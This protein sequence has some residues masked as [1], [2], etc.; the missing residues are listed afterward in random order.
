M[1]LLRLFAVAGVCAGLGAGASA[2]TIGGIDFPDGPISF[3][4]SVVSY[5]PGG[6]FPGTGGCQD[7]SEAVGIPNF[8]GGDCDGYVSLGQGGSIVLQFTDNALT[9]SGDSS[10]DLHVFEIGDAVE[11]MLISISTNTVDW[12]D[13]G[14]LSGQPTSIDIDGVTGVVSGA[15]YSYV[16]I[17]DDPNSG[18]SGGVYSGADIDAVGAISSTA[19]VTPV[20]LPATGLMLVG[21]L[22]AL[23]SAKRRKRKQS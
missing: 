10:A 21:A 18:P 20:P 1:N 3:A 7:T 2:A 19:P 6:G 8:T 4:D 23:A 16:R 14:R 13:L 12:I 5:N 17:I 9:T 11:A 22:G 15:A